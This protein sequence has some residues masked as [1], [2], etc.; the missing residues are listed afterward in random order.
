MMYI[1]KKESAMGKP[2][3]NTSCHCTKLRRS[4][5]NLTA[6]YDALIS[7]AGLTARQ[8]SLLHGIEKGEGCTVRELAGRTELERSTLAR[9]LKPLKAAGLVC[10]GKAPGAR[11]SRLALTEQGRQACAKARRLWAAAQQQ[12][13]EKLGPE[14]LAAL[15]RLL[16]ELQ[17]L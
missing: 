4:A 14:K 10:D 8:Y 12:L 5:E 6:F 11:D 7:P 9:S 1:H 16:E 2:I 3:T 13:E 17:D 15:E